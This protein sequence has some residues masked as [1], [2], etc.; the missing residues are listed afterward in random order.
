MQQQ[1]TTYAGISITVPTQRCAQ[2]SCHT[3]QASRDN[4]D[5]VE[6]PQTAHGAI[7]IQHQMEQK[8]TQHGMKLALPR[9]VRVAMASAVGGESELC[10]WSGGVGGLTCV[11]GLTFLPLF[12]CSQPNR[13]QVAI[14][15][16]SL[17]VLTYDDFTIM[18]FLLSC[19]VFH[20]RPPFP[21][22]PIEVD[23]RLRGLLQVR[24]TTGARRHVVSNGATRAG[25]LT[26]AECCRLQLTAWKKK[27][28]S[29]ALFRRIKRFQKPT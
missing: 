23:P 22:P 20:P 7:Q 17:R 12:S 2:T 3:V 5:D 25:C 16:T 26:A 9:V 10:R 11:N 13:H 6:Q 14:A 8:N 28:K 19:R 4:R 1:H 15:S 24:S 27:K 29:Y 18:V 21:H